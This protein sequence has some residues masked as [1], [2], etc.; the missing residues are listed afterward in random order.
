MGQIN[1]EIPDEIHDKLRVQSDIK[2]VPQKM[3]IQKALKD[4]TDE[5]ETAQ[6]LIEDG[7]EDQK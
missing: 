4:F 1:I 5:F 7:I 3:L 2:R 6:N